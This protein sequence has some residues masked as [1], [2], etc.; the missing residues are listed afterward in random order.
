MRHAAGAARLPR[1]TSQ[2]PSMRPA[3]APTAR[4]A[5][6]V[7]KAK[8]PQAP[9]KQLMSVA[10]ATR[11]PPSSPAPKP[12]TAPATSPEES[13]EHGGQCRGRGGDR[14]R[15]RRLDRWLSVGTRSDEDAEDADSDLDR[16]G[17]QGGWAE[18]KFRRQQHKGLDGRDPHEQR[19]LPDDEGLRK[20]RRTRPRQAQDEQPPQQRDERRD[21]AAIDDDGDGA[22]QP[23]RA[24]QPPRG[25]QLPGGQKHIGRQPQRR[26]VH[27]P[28][29]HA[30][31]PAAALNHAKLLPPGPRDEIA[32]ARGCQ[33]APRRFPRR[34]RT[35]CARRDNWPLGIRRRID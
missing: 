21:R 24:D 11:A 31:G 22:R 13:G 29:A 18:G 35:E 8:K 9:S 2:T 34:P 30:R 28:A 19:G 20:T 3:S 14:E 27:P 6:P 7:K 25:N 5:K 12:S 23:C 16:R 1:R 4:P 32:D 17:C 33:G 10:S 26:H 15:H